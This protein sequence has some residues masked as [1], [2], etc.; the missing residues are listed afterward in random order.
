MVDSGRQVKAFA[1]AAGENGER[2]WSLEEERGEDAI[3]KCA[4]ISR[5]ALPRLVRSDADGKTRRVQAIEVVEPVQ[6]DHRAA[7]ALEPIN[8]VAARL[9]IGDVRQHRSPM[10]V[11]EKGAAGP[12]E[13]R[14][15]RGLAPVV[16][17]D[18]LDP[19]CAKLDGGFP[20]GR[21]GLEAARLEGAIVA[22]QPAIEGRDAGHED[23]ARGEP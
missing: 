22:T 6:L 11:P 4:G 5:Q 7:A 15:I 9:E 13:G 17:G 16:P 21:H 12:P 2:R 8:V 1:L 19:G 18:D 14:D 3:F 23:L 10:V 20:F